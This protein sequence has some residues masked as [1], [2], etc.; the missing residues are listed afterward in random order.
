VKVKVAQNPSGG[1]KR[2]GKGGSPSKQMDK[3][4]P[5]NVR[6]K[7]WRNEKRKGVQL[8]RGVMGV[9]GVGG[10]TVGFFFQ[11]SQ[12]GKKKNGKNPLERRE[13]GS[14]LNNTNTVRMGGGGGSGR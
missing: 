2:T 11:Q 10:V 6:W 9:G 12:G 14:K 8:G 4:T 1:W 13:C 3:N 7:K 5:T